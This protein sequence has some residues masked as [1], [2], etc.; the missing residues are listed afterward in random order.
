M[1]SLTPLERSASTA[2]ASGL[3]ETGAWVSGLNS[4]IS[5]RRLRVSIAEVVGDGEQPRLEA[6]VGVESLQAVVGAQKRLLHEVFDGDLTPRIRID[7]APDQ[8][9]VTAHQLLVRTQISRERAGDELLVVQVRAPDREAPEPLPPATNCHRR[10]VLHTRMSIRPS[11]H[12]VSKK[13]STMNRSPSRETVGSA[14]SPNPDKR[15]GR[16]C[17]LDRG[18]PVDGQAR[19]PRGVVGEGSPST[20]TTLRLRL[21]IRPSR[22]NSL[23][24]LETASLV[25]AIMLARS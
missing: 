13:S 24:T 1:A 20:I 11:R 4:T 23:I 14:R 6:V 21:S 3:R 2:S 18:L 25:E 7:D 8:P 16:A 19:K 22:W 5:L 12:K 9:L 17:C 10:C 15:Q